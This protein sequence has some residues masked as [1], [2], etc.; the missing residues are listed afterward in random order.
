[1]CVRH[2]F[3]RNIIAICKLLKI[4]PTPA[5]T[6]RAAQ[7]FLFVHN[8]LVQMAKK[9]TF[10]EHVVVWGVG[11]L[12]FVGYQ[13]V[14]KAVAQTINNCKMNMRTALHITQISMRTRG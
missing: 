4:C 10:P 7:V 13:I 14:C 3:D 12:R 1:M 8:D 5:Y 2:V 6:L 11:V 9:K